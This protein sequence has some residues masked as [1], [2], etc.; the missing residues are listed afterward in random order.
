MKQAIITIKESSKQ[1][2]RFRDINK[3]IL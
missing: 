1:A 3:E 2:Q